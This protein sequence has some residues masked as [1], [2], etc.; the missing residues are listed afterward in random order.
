MAKLAAAFLFGGF[1]LVFGAVGGMEH[2]PEANFLYQL[3]A[4]VAGLGFMF[5]GTLILPK[6]QE[7]G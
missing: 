7:N 1:L 5:V 3:A 2:Q 6:D 4:A